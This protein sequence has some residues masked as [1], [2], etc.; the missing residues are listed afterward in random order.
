[1]SRP[2]TAMPLVFNEVLTTSRPAAN[3]VASALVETTAIRI[4]RDRHVLLRNWAT[5]VW[6]TPGGMAQTVTTPTQAVLFQL[7]RERSGAQNSTQ[8]GQTT[9][10]ASQS[11]AAD[12]GMLNL[13]LSPGD[14]LIA[15]WR[16]IAN[17]TGTGSCV[18]NGTY[19]LTQ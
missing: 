5:F 19:I 18:I 8:T 11:G 4:P 10:V 17:V 7:Y 2:A 1:M 15:S 3:V 14:V 12:C 13:M 16:G 9:I 6:D